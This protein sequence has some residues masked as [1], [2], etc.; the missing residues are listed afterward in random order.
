MGA[1]LIESALNKRECEEFEMVLQH[2]VDP[3][4]LL[5]SGVD[6]KWMVEFEGYYSMLII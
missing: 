2:T 1:Q 3:K 6:M 4:S 5:I